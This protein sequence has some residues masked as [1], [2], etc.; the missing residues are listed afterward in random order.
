MA[1]RRRPPRRVGRLLLPLPPLVVRTGADTSGTP[2]GFANGSSPAT[3][4]ASP[5]PPRFSTTGRG[6]EARRGKG[7]APLSSRP[8]PPSQRRG[9]HWNI[10]QQPGPAVATDRPP[11][12]F[13]ASARQCKPGAGATER[14]S[15]IM[16]QGGGAATLRTTGDR[17]SVRVVSSQWLSWRRAARGHDRRAGPG[18]GAAEGAGVGARCRHLASWSAGRRP[19]SGEPLPPPPRILTQKSGPVA[20]TG[21]LATGPTRGIKG[22]ALLPTPPQ[23]WGSGRALPRRP[24]PDSVTRGG[25]LSTGTRR[26]SRRGGDRVSGPEKTPARAPAGVVRRSYSLLDAGAA[27]SSWARRPARSAAGARV[28]PRCTPS[29]GGRR[30]PRHPLRAREAPGQRLRNGDKRPCTRVETGGNRDDEG[31]TLITPSG[32]VR[33]PTGC[34]PGGR[35]DSTLREESV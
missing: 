20:H 12:P 19:K 17:A 2:V 6:G 9:R 4:H 13:S 28:S 5:S 34:A 25:C 18:G 1:A 21:L 11:F 23:G 31:N 32:E 29:S 33:C 14:P 8:F 35:V 7:G 15:S 22:L 27:R 24:R 10:V 26:V 30:Q 3:R 16:G